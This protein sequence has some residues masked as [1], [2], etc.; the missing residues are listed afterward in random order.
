MRQPLTGVESIYADI[1]MDRLRVLGYKFTRRRV[2]PRLYDYRQGLE[3][4]SASAD[5]VLDKL[6]GELRLKQ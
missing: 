1:I 6:A 3:Q 2:L 5:W 4:M